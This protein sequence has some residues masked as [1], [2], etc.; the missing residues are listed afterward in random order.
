MLNRGA[1]HLDTDHH[2]PTTTTTMAGLHTPAS[3]PARSVG[4]YLYAEHPTLAALQTGFAIFG[5]IVFVRL[6]WTSCAAQIRSL[7][8]LK[9]IPTCS[10]A[11]PGPSLNEK[12]P[13]YEYKRYTMRSQLGYDAESPQEE[14]LRSKQPIL[15]V[16]TSSDS[17]DRQFINRQ[18]PAPPLTPPELSSTIFTCD[19][20]RQNL[21]DFMH[22]P[23]PDYMAETSTSDA[24][25]A[26][27]TSPVPRLRS[28]RKALPISIP[29]P[30]TSTAS[31]AELPSASATFAPSSY[32]PTSPV[33]PP[34]PSSVA[35][36]AATAESEVRDQSASRRDVDVRGEII[37]AIHSDGAGWT[38]HTRVY[39]GGVCLA[40][41]ASGAQ[42]GQG[43]FYGPNVRPEDMRRC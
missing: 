8:G 3:S 4:K 33:L 18:P 25:S 6:A 5:F 32:P 41:Q 12:K 40:C 34:A 26:G 37:S 36:A 30:Q 24:Q 39:G 13:F 43:G 2:P 23:N 19:E 29:T 28:Y 10:D 31:E 17:L 35:A 42:H 27:Y 1:A 15:T 14:G 21:E 38:R 11:L 20:R 22:Q 9:T 16:H 7:R